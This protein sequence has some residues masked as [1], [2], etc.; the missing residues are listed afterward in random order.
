MGGKAIKDVRPLK[1]EELNST[2]KWVQNNILP[3]LG[4]ESNDVI[5]TGSFLKKSKNQTYGDIDIAINAKKYLNEGIEFNKISLSIDLILKESGFETTLLKGFDQVSVKIPI[6]GD[7]KNGFSQVDLM[8]TPDLKWA[9]FIYHSPNLAEDESK[10][11]GAVRNALLMSLVSEP[12]K[13]ITK[14]FEG[15]IEEYN[16]LSIRFSTGLW[17]IK[18]S[19][20][21]K[22]GQ[23]IKNGIVLDSEFISNNP[24]DIIDIALGEGYKIDAAN[25]F[26]TLWEIIH[27]KD[28]INK[29][30]LNE[31][32]HKFKE[33]LKSMQQDIP[34]ETIKKYSK[35]LNE[36]IQDILK[37]KLLS[38]D[39]INSWKNLEEKIEKYI[40]VFKYD[41]PNVY[42]I[43]KRNNFKSIELCQCHS[44][45]GNYIGCYNARCYSFENLSSYAKSDCIKEIK[46]KFKLK[47]DIDFYEDNNKFMIELLDENDKISKFKRLKIGQFIKEWRDKN[48][49]HTYVTAWT[50]W[51]GNNHKTLVLNSEIGNNNIEEVNDAKQKAI[52]FE[53]PEDINVSRG[54]IQSKETDNYIFTTTIYADDPWITSVEE[55]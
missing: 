21:G 4:L 25:S 53:F 50:Y 38:N 11:K 55:K 8:P 29:N 9:K 22:K 2:Y 3:I 35:V 10:Y 1:Y 36:G 52:L 44:G 5:P 34:E 33:N 37:P 49:V 12:S 15:K 20:M 32:I 43:T 30:K 31:I 23:I 42:Y 27:K 13:D 7:E 26:E 39:Q 16:S 45:Y 28:F 14:L 19:F 48:E 17:N 6:N 47:F 41:D 46:E 24:Q 54:A 51:N 18:R 40:V